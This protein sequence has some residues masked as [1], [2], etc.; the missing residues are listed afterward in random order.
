M[1]QRRPV[2]RETPDRLFVAL[3]GRSHVDGNAFDLAT[4]IVSEC[5]PAPGMQSEHRKILQMCQAPMAVV[6]VSA[7][8]GLPVGAVKILLSDLRD[9]GRITVRHSSSAPDRTQPI[10]EET[11]EKVLVGLRNL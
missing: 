5:D 10:P 4:L 6:E 2:D 9:V 8:L 1:D 3:G 7:I 11:L